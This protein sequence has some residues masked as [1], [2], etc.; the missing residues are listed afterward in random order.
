MSQGPS[1]CGADVMPLHHVP[2]T[3]TPGHRYFLNTEHCTPMGCHWWHVDN[4]R[5]AT[6]SISHKATTGGRR[7]TLASTLLV[8]PKYHTVGCRSVSAS[9]VCSGVCEGP[10]LPQV[11][12]DMHLCNDH[13]PRPRARHGSWQTACLVIS[14]HPV[15]CP[16]FF[17]CAGG[18]SDVDNRGRNP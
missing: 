6:L 16:A 11:V 3:A 2:L 18:N 7:G 15:S 10:W 12:D 8:R 5:G 17:F 1:A 4:N 14:R 9:A 13:A